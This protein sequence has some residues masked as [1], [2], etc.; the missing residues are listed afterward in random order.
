MRPRDSVPLS[1]IY[2]SGKLKRNA[3]VL[4]ETVNKISR[5]EMRFQNDTEKIK[6]DR[7]QLYIEVMK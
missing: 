6:K 5:K 1:Y 3:L 7:Y 2:I 4:F